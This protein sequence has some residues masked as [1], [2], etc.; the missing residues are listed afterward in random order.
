M[1]TNTLTH[2]QRQI[3][4]VIL[5]SKFVSEVAQLKIENALQTAKF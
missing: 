3:H 4:N 1:C 2:I 5:V